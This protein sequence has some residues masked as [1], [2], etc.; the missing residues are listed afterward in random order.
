TP[1]EIAAAEA[2]LASLVADKALY[3]GKLTRTTLRMPFDG[4]ILTLHLK[5]R[6]NSYLNQGDPFAAVEYT[7]TV[8]PQI[9]INESDL[10]YVKIGAKVRMHPT[11]NSAGTFAADIATFQ[12]KDGRL[13]TGMTG[14]AKIDGPVIPVWQAFT[15]GLQQF[16]QVDVWSWVP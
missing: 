13:K 8:T 16:F 12:N 5:D 14:E 11:T 2:K 3:E 4:N 6:I 10:Q 1:D 9:D 7:G 15:Q